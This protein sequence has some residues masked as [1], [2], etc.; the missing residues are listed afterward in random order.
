MRRL[1]VGIGSSH[2]ALNTKSQQ[3]NMSFHS[4]DSLSPSKD[5]KVLSSLDALNSSIDADSTSSTE[6]ESSFSKD[7]FTSEEDFEIE[8]PRDIE[9]HPIFES[10]YSFGCGRNGKGRD[11]RTKKG[12]FGAMSIRVFSIVAAIIALSC[13]AVGVTYPVLNRANKN[14]RW[15]RFLDNKAHTLVKSIRKSPTGLSYTIRLKGSR[16][17]LLQQSL[18]AHSRCSSVEEIQVDYMG[19]Q[20]L[21][22]TVYKHGAGKAMAVGSPTTTSGVFLLTEGII[23]SCEDLDKAFNTWRRDPRRIVGF[24]AYNNNASGS[25]NRIG[26]V[27]GSAADA[28]YSLVSDKAAFVHNQYLSAFESFST[29]ERCCPVLLSMQVSLTSQLPP[30]LMK[31]KPRELVDM[32]SNTGDSSQFAACSSQCTQDWLRLGDLQQLPGSEVAVLGQ[33]AS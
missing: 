2:K 28:Q 8:T 26:A 5:F 21:P 25:S 31:S 24:F 3:G 16:L 23:F 4:P 29:A 17:H 27:A 13:I 20:V 18:D 11:W 9:R 10:E 12:L 22:N 1:K 32:S 6:I 7:S 15:H 19:G 30:V 14:S 33:W